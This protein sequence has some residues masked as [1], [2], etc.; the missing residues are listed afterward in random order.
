MKKGYS[1]QKGKSKL[2]YLLFIDD[3]KLSGSNR[4]AIAS[5]VRI[6]EI[7]TKDIGMNFSIY[8]CGDLA[9][10]RGEK[11]C[12]GTE[13][14][15]GEEIGQIGEE[16]YKYPGILEEEDICQEEIKKTLRKNT[17]RG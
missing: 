11:E 13:L 17:L 14:K 1:F 7:V 3:L 8:K 16:G 2:N 4:N 15:S 12:D 9:M 10:K 5:L 6:V